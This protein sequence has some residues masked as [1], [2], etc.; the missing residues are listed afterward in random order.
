VA[1]VVLW[2]ADARRTDPTTPGI[3]R[4]VHRPGGVLTHWRR[5]GCGQPVPGMI[6]ARP[7]AVRRLAVMQSAATLFRPPRLPTTIFCYSEG[8]G[9]GGGR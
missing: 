2:T 4:L 8:G 5:D 1:A 3:R 7:S 6:N 9:T